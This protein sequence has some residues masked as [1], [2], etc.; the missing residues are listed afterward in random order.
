[1]KKIYCLFVSVVTALFLVGCQD[2]DFGVS[3]EQVFRSSYE[4]NFIEKNGSVSSD[5]D[6]DFSGIT[7]AATGWTSIAT[8]SAYNYKN[9][10]VG[11][12][13]DVQD[14]LVNWMQTQLRE[15]KKP[16]FEVKAF[17]MVAQPNEIFEIVPIYLGKSWMNWELNIV[18]EIGDQLVTKTIWSKQNHGIQTKSNG[19]DWQD[20][21]VG[22]NGGNGS[23]HD[24]NVAAMRA[25]PFVVD[26]SDSIFVGMQPDA[27]V[28]FTLKLTTSHA[29]MGKA[30]DVVSSIATPPNFV[31][32]DCPIDLTG[33]QETTGY[34]TMLIG[35][36]EES[37]QHD[38]DYN[39]A[40]FL[41][42]G[43]VPQVI[44]QRDWSY[45]YT[46][47]RYLVE[48]LSAYDYD[49]NDVV[50]DVTETVGQVYEFVTDTDGEVTIEALEGDEYKSLK[51]EAT[52][53]YLCGTMPIQVQVGNFVFGQI[54]DPTNLTEALRQAK[55]A[56][57][58]YGDGTVFDPETSGDPGAE[59]SY[60]VTIPDNSWKPEENNVSV[61][62]W[63]LA[64]ITQSKTS[65]GVWT[66][67]F[68]E[69]GSVPYII[70]VPQ[71]TAWTAEG[72]R[73][74]YEQYT[75]IANK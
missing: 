16:A 49:F 66:S 65:D 19:S 9:E 33:I 63:Q 37:R 60:T 61:Y 5:Q 50:V 44:R 41:V 30:G 8:D 10:L 56:G 14:D 75:N 22:T 4:R 70:A 51:Q 3:Q 62:V 68:P 40:V 73:F 48:D 28:Y 21:S 29:G 7:R 12:Y 53:R 32:F 67:I 54:T 58:K 1:M 72:V 11:V 52:I 55:N 6:W 57:D 64:D 34:E 43:Y 36:D 69:R 26:F 38:W 13:Y 46:K 23:T 47:K 2:E 39:D 27:P 35:C 24:S 71:S 31:V 20:F 45:T 25:L 17:T 74:P 18:V 42:A 59:L 15:G